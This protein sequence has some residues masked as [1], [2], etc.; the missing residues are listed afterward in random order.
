VEDGSAATELVLSKG[1]RF[2]CVVLDNQ[3]PRQ[4]RIFVFYIFVG[5]K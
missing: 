2:H 4:V 5:N 1:E 3:M